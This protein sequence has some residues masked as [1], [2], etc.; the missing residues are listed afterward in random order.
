MVLET[1]MEITA[2]Q[3]SLERKR[4]SHITLPYLKHTSITK[5]YESCQA[6]LR[7]NPIPK[8]R[9]E[10]RKWQQIKTITHR[11]EKAVDA[12]KL[13]PAMFVYGATRDLSQSNSRNT[14][15]YQ[16]RS[17]NTLL[18]ARLPDDE[19]PFVNVLQSKLDNLIET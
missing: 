5:R 19:Q 1:C 15:L 11:R 12:P 17:T 14:T 8:P 10:S 2:K 6:R 3:L 18:K 4:K 13:M 9:L 7:D 16:P